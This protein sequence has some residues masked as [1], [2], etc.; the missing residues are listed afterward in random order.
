MAGARRRILP[1][2]MVGLG[3]TVVSLSAFLYGAPFVQPLFLPK[4]RYEIPAGYRGWVS[5]DLSNPRCPPSLHQGRFRVYIVDATGH[6]CTSDPVAEGWRS[7]EYDSLGGNGGR[8]RLPETSWGKGGLIWGPA[9][10]RQGST[11]RTI[12]FVGTEQQFTSAA[13]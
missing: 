3:V 8:R 10:Q 4:L 13:K 12:F 9:L 2:I 5:I 1:W 7:I 6:G 11:K